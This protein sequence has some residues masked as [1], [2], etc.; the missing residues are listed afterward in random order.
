M[1]TTDETKELEFFN[2]E[3]ATET[4]DE[5]LKTIIEKDLGKEIYKS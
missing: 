1:K 3:D 4:L 5:K 2:S